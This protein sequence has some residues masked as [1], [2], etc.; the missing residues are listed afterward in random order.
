[1]LHVIMDFADNDVWEQQRWS[2]SWTGL[3]AMT[4]ESYNRAAYEHSR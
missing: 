4:K 3:K 2:R 1:M